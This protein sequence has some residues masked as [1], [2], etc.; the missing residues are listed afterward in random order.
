MKVVFV[1]PVPTGNVVSGLSMRANSTFEA[2]ARW[3]EV[4]VASPRSLS[5]ESRIRRWTHD[6]VPQAYKSCFSIPSD[7]EVAESRAC[8]KAALAIVESKPELI[9]VFR[10]CMEPF[11]SGVI[12]KIPSQLDLDE[13]EAHTRR[14]LA[15]LARLNGD[16]VRAE[17]WDAEAEFY[18]QAERKLLPAFERIFVS[19]E[20]ERG[21]VL[22]VNP[23]LQVELLPN[24]VSI[25]ATSRQRREGGPF[26]FLFVGGL[27]YYP[28]EDGVRFLIR[29]VLPHLEL[30][31][32]EDFRVL[33]A[34]GSASEDLK[35]LIASTPR[36]EAAGFVP[37]LGALYGMADAVLIPLRAGGGTRIKALEAFAYQVP[38]VSTRLGVEGLPVSDGVEVEIGDGAEGF[39]EACVRMVENSGLRT[40]LARAAY[41]LVTTRFSIQ[42]LEK[43]LR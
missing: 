35:T 15:D 6:V 11:V 28:N 8:R 16:S 32:G 9:H 42:A 37:E 10:F 38:V 13:S 26:T 39:A 36:V 29:E 2:L 3:H 21:L 34:G 23:K 4:E 20:H 5:F 7:W 18:A 17:I 25:P 24:V 14:R 43:T 1:S 33:V 40:E 30:R 31:L 27:G 41:E 12:G 19:S 22:E